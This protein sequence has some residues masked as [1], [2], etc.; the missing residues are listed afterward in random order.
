MEQQPD[1]QPGFYYVTVRDPTSLRYCILRGPFIND[2]AAALAAV[3]EAMQRAIQSD[4][5]GCWYEYGTCRAEFDLGPGLFDKLDVE[6]A[7]GA[8]HLACDHRDRWDYA[9]SRMRPRAAKES[10]S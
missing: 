2:H 5:R 10:R 4:P 6:A 1:T 7:Q 9:D 3:D 8:P